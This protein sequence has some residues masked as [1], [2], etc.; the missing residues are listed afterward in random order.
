MLIGADLFLGD[1]QV[2]RI[3]SIAGQRGSG[4]TAMAFELAS[5]YLK[6]GYKLI[7]N[8]D[9]IWQ[10]DYLL[11]RMRMDSEYVKHS[12]II[13][14]EGGRYLREWKYFENMF[15]FARKFDNIILIPSVRI[16][17]ENLAEFV[18]RPVTW[19]QRV[20]PIGLNYWT[21]TVKTGDQDIFGSFWFRASD[22]IG[23]YD[24]LDV[25][26]NPKFIIESFSA[27][28]AEEAK[29][30]GRSIESVL[31]LASDQESDQQAALLRGQE[32]VARRLLSVSKRKGFRL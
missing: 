11:G 4:K 23:V 17:H 9:N 15:E 32:K 13:L 19:L 14:D 2:N 3:L 5:W 25:S 12:I 24:T 28:I 27:C 18:C 20:L 30:R 8:I 31:G 16:A 21:Y 7:T 1:L 6:R 26:Q 29:R 22:S 10:E